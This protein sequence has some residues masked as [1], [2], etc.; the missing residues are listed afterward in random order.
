MEQPAGNWFEPGFDAT[1]WKEGLSGFGTRE[2]PGAAVRTEWRTSDIWLR[3]EFAI[4]NG[5]LDNLK[6]SIHHDEDAEVY[7]NGVLAA[8]APGYTTDYQRIELSPEAKAS[9]KP[10]GNILA[11]HCRQTAGGQYI[12]VGISKVLPP[13]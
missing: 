13:K 6:L 2:T 12:D 1:S 9:L 8:K 11:V 4:K 3:R 10:T 5:Q 7:I